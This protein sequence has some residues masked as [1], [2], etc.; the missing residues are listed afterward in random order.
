MAT[1][2][3]L[4]VKLDADLTA[5][6]RGMDKATGKVRVFD[7]TAGGATG[8]LTKLS[9]ST[10]KLGKTATRSTGGLGRLN[11]A[12]VTMTRQA[13][14]MPPI[15]GRLT[16]V[17][18][19]FAIG[20]GPMI[21]IL[22]GIAAIAAGFAHITREAR[23]TSKA[24]K[25]AGERIQEWYDIQR[26]QGDMPLIKDLNAA[27]AKLQQIADK[28]ARARDRAA[29]PVTGSMGVNVLAAQQDVRDLEK[30]LADQQTAV[31][32]ARDRRMQPANQRQEADAKKATDD[33]TKSLAE[34]ARA[35]EQA[36]AAQQRYTVA[37][38]ANVKA[39]IASASQIDELRRKQVAF[40][41]A[42]RDTTLAVE[43][44]A[45]AYRNATMA[46]DALTRAQNRAVSNRIKTSGGAPMVRMTGA[47][48]MDPALIAELRAGF[49]SIRPPGRDVQGGLMANTHFGPAGAELMQV[50]QAASA[51]LGP[52]ALLIPVINSALQ[53]LEPILE[54]II[55]PLAAIGTMLAKQ[56][57]PAL[58]IVAVGLRVLATVTS[59]VQEALGRFVKAIG[60]AV[61]WLLP[62]NPANR[63]VE[64]GQG[65]IDSA[66]AARNFGDAM[67][68]NARQM[69]NVPIS[70]NAGHARYRVGMGDTGRTA[71]NR[72]SGTTI[73]S[74]T[75]FANSWR[76]IAREMA[77]A[78]AG[79]DPLARAL[80]RA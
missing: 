76:D 22:A 34:A 4:T 78:A 52:F 53:S 67:N 19:T 33:R 40:R 50:A 51:G 75:I 65:M 28:L 66:K 32:R 68:E 31:D 79:G 60:D 72:N 27:E 57:E 1:I 74:V 2:D 18:G 49:E 59:Y 21:P 41:D 14:G 48:Q 77:A 5:F 13:T 80:L 36:A 38:A 63:L 43:E 69:R 7:K 3:T 15:M 54:T 45:E 24:A 8:G 6:D 26:T 56:L 12:F 20:V 46:A 35:A 62:G 61:N 70:F 44:Q 39:G 16:D 23:E 17:L 47:I 10:E 64:F 55:E 30:A 9:G 58:K 42:S 25:E 73:G 37:L 71:V 11:D 29:A